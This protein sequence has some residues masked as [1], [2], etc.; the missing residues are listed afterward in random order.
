MSLYSYQHCVLSNFRIFVILI[1]ENISHAFSYIYLKISGVELP[2]ICLRLLLKY[3]VL[4][5]NARYR[6]AER[7]GDNG[8]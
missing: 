5:E 3:S 1:G 7:S 2:F 4:I 8:H 6:K